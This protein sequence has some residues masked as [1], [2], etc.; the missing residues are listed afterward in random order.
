MGIRDINPKYHELLPWASC[1]FIEHQKCII[2]VVDI[3]INGL[4]SPY[5]NNRPSRSL[6]AITMF[7]KYIRLNSRSQ[8]HL[9]EHVLRQF[10]NKKIIPRP[11]RP[12]KR[13]IVVVIDDH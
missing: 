3:Q 10:G 9:L 8:C 11:S 1:Y 6:K 13:D 4:W 12:F 7:S 5:D 2:G